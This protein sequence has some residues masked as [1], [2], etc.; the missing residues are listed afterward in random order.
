[1][2][3]L[4][5]ITMTVAVMLVLLFAGTAIAADNNSGNNYGPGYCWSWQNDQT[6]PSSSPNSFAGPSC[7]QW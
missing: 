2:K 6:S 7:H 3:K 1:M 5:V 4:I